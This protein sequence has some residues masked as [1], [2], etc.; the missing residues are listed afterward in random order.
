MTEIDTPK[1]LNDVK[2]EP[3]SVPS[4]SLYCGL[5]WPEK[6]FPA[7]CCTIGEKIPERGK[8]FEP[9]S[10]GYQIYQ[11][12]EAKTFKDLTDFLKDVPKYTKAIYAMLEPRYHSYIRDFNR[13][14]RD[15]GSDLSLKSTRS[16]NFEASLLKIKALVQSNGLTFP[17]KSL[18]R[19]QLAMFSKANLS[20]EVEYYAVRSLSLVIGAFD[21][22]RNSETGEVV[23]K[24]RSWW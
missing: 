2:S 23:P 20:D 12:C 5:V 9:G 22:K 7:Y 24:L 13:W 16:S 4:R 15:T 21:V 17:P 6:G 3:K 11:E 18:I 8:S 1:S 14:K 10:V 19:S